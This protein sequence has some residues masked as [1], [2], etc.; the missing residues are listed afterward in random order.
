M[1]IAHQYIINPPLLVAFLF[2]VDNGS[3][4]TERI[5]QPAHI[6]SNPCRCSQNGNRCILWYGS[7]NAHLGPKCADRQAGPVH[8]PKAQICKAKLWVFLLTLFGSEQQQQQQQL[9]PSSQ[10][11]RGESTGQDYPTFFLEFP[12]CWPAHALRRQLLKEG[13]VTV[14]RQGSG[15]GSFSAMVR[16]GAGKKGSDVKTAPSPPRSIMDGRL[17]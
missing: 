2:L 6:N 5:S 9:P 8:E 13:L 14:A 1:Q 10:K 12:S 3:S 4:T 16:G 7:Q 11:G 17:P 15:R